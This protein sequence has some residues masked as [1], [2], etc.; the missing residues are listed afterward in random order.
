[1][2]GGIGS[3][4]SE[5]VLTGLA[6]RINDYLRGGDAAALLSERTLS[7]IG[8]LTNGKEPE[9]LD[10]KTARAAGLVHWHRYHAAWQ[11]AGTDDL[12]E[13]VRFFRPLIVTRPD[14]VPPQLH[15]L[16]KSGQQDNRVP[17]DPRIWAGRAVGLLDRTV[18]TGEPEP[19]DEAITLLR[20]ALQIAPDDDPDG[21]GWQANLGSALATRFEQTGTRADLD[22]AVGYLTAVVEATPADATH[23]PMDLSNLGTALRKR[24]DSTGSLADLDEAIN[25]LRVAAATARDA[26]PQSPGY[27]SNLASALRGRFDYTGSLTDLNSAIDHLQAAVTLAPEDHPSRPVYLSNLGN[28]LRRRYQQTSDPEDLDHAIEWLRLAT[29]ETDEEHRSWARHVFNLGGALLIRFRHSDRPRDLDESIALLTKAVEYTPDADPS[30]AGR[31]STLGTALRVRSEHTANVR[32][33]TD[34]IDLLE[35]AVKTCAVHHPDRAEYLVNF[36]LALKSRFATTG[37]YVDFL[38]AVGAWQQAAKARLARAEV[39]ATAAYQWGALA[40]SAAHDDLALEGYGEAVGLLPLLSWR[41]LQRNDQL[42]QLGR[43]SDLTSDGGACALTA[44]QR[45]RAMEL[46]EQGRT[47]LWTQTLET[48]TDLSRLAEAAPVLADRMKQIRIML[49]DLAWDGTH[50]RPRD[51]PR[52]GRIVK[53]DQ[54]AS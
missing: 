40:A 24:F 3:M 53:G 42:H 19:L 15:P 1:M 16:L 37:S 29:Q 44:D 35:A 50:T 45:H 13:A 25:Y 54:Q 8:A 49:D 46:L 52:T 22:E 11:E 4:G 5:H 30:R 28:A 7:D 33:L 41:G 10:L 23:R 21:L 18:R 36:G 34:A 43:W 9:S 38:A 39:R 20:R 31:L 27:L 48:R 12:A 32:D 17:C 47:V 2:P 6:A 14:L 51:T 26:D